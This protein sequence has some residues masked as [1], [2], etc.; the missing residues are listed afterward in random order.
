MSVFD[1]DDLISTAD[2]GWMLQC[3]PDELDA[4][5]ATGAIRAFEQLGVIWFLRED[6]MELARRMRDQPTKFRAAS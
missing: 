4:I 3:T 1:V 2:A 6:V 5:V